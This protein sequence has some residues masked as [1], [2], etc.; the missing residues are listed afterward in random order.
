MSGLNLGASAGLRARAG[1]GGAGSTAAA[2]TT[3]TSAAYGPSVTGGGSKVPAYGGIAA[4]VIALG[5]LAY[6]WWSLPR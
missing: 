5:L 6:L 2:P 1:V 3:I 4:G